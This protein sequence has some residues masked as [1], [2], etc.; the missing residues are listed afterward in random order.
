MSENKRTYKQD[1]TVVFDKV[2]EI[3]QRLPSFHIVETNESIRRIRL[4]TLPSLFSYGENV[5]IIVQ[6][7]SGGGSLVYVRSDPKIFFNITAGGA[8]QRNITQI[9][10][11]LDEALG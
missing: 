2:K 3:T 9:F 1:V 10:Q 11:A 4:S 5:E 7:Q 8:V 6:P